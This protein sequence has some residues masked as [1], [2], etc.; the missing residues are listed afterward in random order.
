MNFLADHTIEDYEPINFDF[1]D[2]DLM[3][4]LNDDDEESKE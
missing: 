1:L 2:K 3:A 4:M